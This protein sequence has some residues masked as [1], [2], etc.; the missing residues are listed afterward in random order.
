MSQSLWSAEGRSCLYMQIAARAKRAQELHK[1]SKAKKAATEPTPRTL[2]YD[3]AKVL[4][5]WEKGKSIREI[6]EAMKPISRVFVHR[7]LTTKFAKQ[8]A[9]GQKQRAAA[10]AKATE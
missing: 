7:T 6:A 10:R 3:P 2:K 9:E 5:L 1:M 8:Y 4:Q